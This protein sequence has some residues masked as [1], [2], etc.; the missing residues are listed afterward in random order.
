MWCAIFVITPIM[1]VITPIGDCRVFLYDVQSC[2][3]SSYE[4][5]YN[6]DVGLLAI[7]RVDV[8]VG[9]LTIW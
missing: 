5:H 1:G 7:G 4:R 9:E 6:D 8:A 2:D 3:V